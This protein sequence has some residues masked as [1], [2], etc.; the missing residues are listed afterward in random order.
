MLTLFVCLGES[1]YKDDA[2][3]AAAEDPKGNWNDWWKACLDSKCLSD[4]A[5]D[6]K[7]AKDALKVAHH[8]IKKAEWGWQ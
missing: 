6:E 1:D 2:L 3:K 5:E 4:N 8:N 7:L